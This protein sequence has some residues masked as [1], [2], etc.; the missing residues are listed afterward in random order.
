MR[1]KK[2]WTDNIAVRNCL[3][4][5][6]RYRAPATR[7]SAQPSCQLRLAWPPDPLTRLLLQADGVTEADF[8]ALL[9]R[10]AAALAGR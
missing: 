10:A 4:T 1:R 8:D 5:A 7:R 3:P 9:R 6:C 2:G